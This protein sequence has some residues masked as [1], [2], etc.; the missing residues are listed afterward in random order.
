MKTPNITWL[1]VKCYLSNYIEVTFSTYLVNG[2][3]TENV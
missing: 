1:I 2:V 3:V